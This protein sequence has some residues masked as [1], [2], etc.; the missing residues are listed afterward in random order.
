MAEFKLGRIRFVWKGDW[1]GS[2]TYYKDDVVR[3]GGKTFICSVGHT[4]N[5]DFYVDFDIVPS[6][7]NLM[8]D[9]TSWKGDWSTSTQYIVNDVVKYGG[10]LYIA[11]TAHTSAATAADGLELDS[12]KWSVYAE[13]FDWKGS[14]VAATRY[15]LNDLVKYGGQT[16]VCNTGHTSAATNT[17]GLEADQAKWDYFNQGVEYKGAWVGSTRYKVN[18]I[19][20]YGANLYICTGAHTADVSDFTADSANWSTFVEGFEFA[21]TWNDSAAYKIGDVVKYGGNQYV[22]KTNN[23][24]ANP[25]SSGADW[26]LFAEG[27]SFQNAWNHTTSYKIGEVVSNNG[28]TYVATADSPSTDYTI[29]ATNNGTGIFTTSDTSGM[30]VG[31]AIK[32]S[33]TTFGNVSDSSLYFIKTVPDAVTFTISEV[34]AGATFIPDTA[35]GSM[36]G[37]VAAHPTEPNYWGRLNEGFS[38][39]GEWTDD[40][41]YEVGDAVKFGANAYICVTRHRSEGDDGSSIGAEGGGAANSRPDQDTTGTYWNQLITGSETALLT[42]PGDLVYYGGSGV[43]RLPIGTEGQVLSAGALYPEWVSLGQSDYVYYVAEHGVDAPYPVYGGTID[44]P[45]KS[46]RYACMQVENGPR[47]PNAQHILEMNRAF[48]QRE[49]VEYINYNVELNTITTPDVSSIW[50]NLDYKDDRCFRDVGFVLDAL[51]FDLGHG[52]NVKTRGAA[53]SFVGGLSESETEAYPQLGAESAVS[54]AAYTYMWQ[55]IEK[56][57][58]NQD[59]DTNYQV[60]NGD[61]STAVILQHKN[62]E[63]VPEAGVYTQITSLLTIVLNALEDQDTTRIPA[64]YSPNNLIKVKTGR[65]RETLPIIVPENTCVIGDEVRSVNAG[66]SRGT[67]HKTDTGYSLATYEHLKSVIGNV[68]KGSS[69]TPTSGNAEAQDIAVPFA[70]TVEE[71]EISKLIDTM[72]HNIDFRVGTLELANYADPVG[73]NTSYLTGYGNA[74]H[75]LLENKDFV[76]EELT[77]WIAANYPNVKYSRTKCKQDVGYIVDALVYDLTYGGWKMTIDAAT[78]YYDGIAGSLAIDSS[79]KAA[80]VAAYGELKSLLSAIAGNGT[81]TPLNPTIPQYRDTAGSAGAVAHVEAALDVIIATINDVADRPNVTVTNIASNVITTSGNHSL[82]VGDKFTPRTSGNGFVADTTFWVLTTPAANTL[83]VSQTFG[84]TTMPLSDGSG[85][86]IIADVV[87]TP[88]A[89]NGVTSTTALITA[90]ETLDAQQEAIVTAMSNYLATTYPDLTYNEAKCKRDMRLLLEGA[91]YDFMFDSNYQTIKNAYAYLRSTASDVYDLGQKTATRAAYDYVR[92]L[93]ADDTAT[94]LNSDATAASRFAALFHTIDTIIYSGS[95]EGSR[96]ATD[97]RNAD[98]ARLQLERNRAFIVAEAD[99]Y[100][101]TTYK[102]TA[103][104]TTATTDNITVGDTSWMKRGMAI[105]FSGTVLTPPITVGGDGIVAGTTYY[106]Y[107]VVSSTEVQIAKTRNA[108]GAMPLDDDTGSMGVH[109]AYNSALC[110]RDVNSVI[111]AIKYDIKFKGN[112]KVLYAARYYGNAVVGSH[113]EDMYYLRNGTGIRNQTMDGMDGDLLAPNQYGTSRVSGGAYVSLDPGWGPE[114]Y[115]VWITERSPYVQNNTTFG[116]GAIGQKI[117]GAL[118]NGGNDSIV[119]NDFTQVIS[120]G[121]GAWV[122]NNG[123]AE[124]V[125]VFTYYSHIGYLSTDG[126]RIRGTNGNNSYGDFGSV[127]EGFDATETPNTAIVDNRFQFEAVVSEVNTDSAQEVYNFEFENA[128]NEYTKTEILVSGAGTGATALADEFRNNAVHN[129]FLEDNVDDSADAPEA[130]GNFGGFGY[131]SNANTAQGGTST[132]ITLAATDAEISSAYIGMVVYID[133]GAGVGQYGVITGYNS[134]TKIATVERES[135][136]TPGWDHVVPG[137]TISAP[138]ASSTYVVQPRVQFTAPGF[139]SVVTAG[140]MP[141]AGNWSAQGYGF[142]TGVYIVSPTGGTGNGLSIQVIR[143]GWKYSTSIISGGTGYTRLDSLTIVGSDVGG[144]DSTHDITLVATAINSSTGEIIEY[145]QEGYGQPGVFVAARSG[146]TNGAYSIDGTAWNASTLPSASNWTA[147]G[148]G[149]I[150]DGSTVA[151]QSRFVAVASGT[152]AAAYSNDGITWVSSVMPAS[153]NWSDI[154]FLNGRFVAIASD[155]TTVAISLDG[156]VWD[157]TGTLNS[158]G[159]N[160]IAAGKGRLVAVKSGSTA[161]AYSVDGE[162]WTDVTLPASI[163]WNS[164][165]WGNGRFVA[166]ATDSD[167]GAYSLDGLTWGSMSVGSPDSTTPSGLQ[168]LTYNEGLFM[169]TAYNAGV[170]GF[171]YVAHSPDGIVWTW[172]GY[173]NGNIGESSGA[174]AIAFGLNKER[175]GV[176]S[177]IGGDAS[178]DLHVQIFAGATAK[179][180]AYVAEN[181]IFKITIVEPGSGYT[182]APTMTITDPSEIYAVPFQ[183]RMGYGVLANP[184]FTSRGTGYVSASADL[185][186]GTGDGYADF[187]Q[188]G[189]FIAVRRLT[190]IPVA[191]SNVVFGHLPAQTFKLVNIFTLLGSNSGSY[192]CFLQVSPEMKLIDVP[193]D[194]TSITT[195]IKY[196]QVR[197]TGHDFLDI[198]TG[199]FT[200]TNYP[201][202]PLQDPIPANETKEENGGRVFYTSTDQDGNFRVGGLF[203]VEQSTGVATLNADAFNIA[204]L[205]ELTLG[206]VTLGGGSASIEEFSTD[207]FFTADSDNVVPTQR[208]I[209]AYISSQIGGGGASLNVNSVTAGF[210]YIAGTQITTTTGAQISINANM[211]FKGSVDGYPL[212]WSYFLN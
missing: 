52:G 167:S 82:T 47:N 109:L 20:K 11:T 151:L 143:N 176:Y 149:L 130:L 181:K 4:S 110:L 189:S 188:S 126:G 105:K 157:I 150:D 184:T 146:A 46:I 138:D 77:L 29:T 96:C 212:A 49:V 100:I 163:A 37:T 26:A 25:V 101:N 40:R 42:T 129:I 145:D 197:L 56:V 144:T 196:S 98:Y 135:T 179:G 67:T 116:N 131:V 122:A 142:T 132:S 84:G 210:I 9:G 92:T 72:M 152:T 158:T 106:V 203:A 185:I 89:T 102:T 34:H 19:I 99:A 171:D 1:A 169:A 209:K 178:D 114:D 58:N 87:Y 90:A 183:V 113:E 33:G 190:D 175:R 195:R 174:K 81:I 66:P 74:R 119:S 117:D 204:G 166:I 180:R 177:V 211:N 193:A 6:K 134:G 30:V 155:S 168:K 23:T 128:G 133:G 71:T 86:S 172:S 170:N 27:F 2:T 186:N 63:E 202:L 140:G 182:S 160:S 95:T 3:Y 147:I 53:N 206:E 43:A 107:D 68:V 118:H 154:A 159:W 64:R 39:Q 73:Y 13:G 205:Q 62:T 121:I 94:Y 120:D 76:K 85:L 48:I 208:A 32:F 111:D 192:T 194:G 164:V 57:I 15:K 31:Q 173:G 124:L 83:T 125:S 115:R 41:E 78:A 28:Y 161:A 112:Y 148:H 12:A 187:L 198:G 21:N 75:L 7:W 104:A 79:E 59:P 70:D 108:S 5:A 50:Y 51:I 103:T 136:G 88:A 162:T 10:N 69:V 201:G 55:L 127:A 199:N 45:F 93:I 91:M 14:W 36:T 207:P 17:L 139:S 24:A 65:Y 80:T 97:I 16:Y 61:L 123:R 8:T 153:A 60:T 22:A 44:K 191:G 35:V 200:E 141:T 18:D 137:T 54:V 38:W 165:K 156:I